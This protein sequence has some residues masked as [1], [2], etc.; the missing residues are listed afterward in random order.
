MGAVHEEICSNLGF[1][2]IYKCSKTARLGLSLITMLRLQF[3]TP[4]EDL[5]ILKAAYRS[6][7]PN[8]AGWA[9]LLWPNNSLSSMGL[10]VCRLKGEKAGNPCQ[11]HLTCDET[12]WA[13]L[14]F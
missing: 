6:G 14:S 13:L 12:S 7:H 9:G 2:E 1:C 4:R 10:A 8:L 11:Q 5:T 3:W